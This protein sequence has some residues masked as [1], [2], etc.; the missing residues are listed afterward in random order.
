[1]KLK[2]AA[3][4]L[5][6][7]MLYSLPSHAVSQ[8]AGIAPI[9]VDPATTEFADPVVVLRDRVASGTASIADIKRAIEIGKPGDI[10]NVLAAT[11]NMRAN[12]QVRSLLFDMWR[13]VKSTH[14]D[15]PWQKLQH[16]VIR[17]ALAAV[18]NR[19]AAGTIPEFMDYLR[20]QADSDIDLVRA[21]VAVALGMTGYA[22][23]IPLLKK[24]AGDESYYVAKSAIL[25]LGYVYNDEARQTLIELRDEYSG[26]ARGVY[27]TG[28]LREAYHW[29]P[30]KTT[31]TVK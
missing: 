28:M 27:I 20:S 3:S 15:L 13:E 6:C 12:A 1:V 11:Y 4:F 7:V 9:T 26:T 16:P 18:M 10:A 31:S 21:Q 25:G 29:Q 17:T 8:Q 24:Y 2:L 14:A 22:E 19:I 23:D 5:G 30:V